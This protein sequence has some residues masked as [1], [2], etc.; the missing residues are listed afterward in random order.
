MNPMAV[1]PLLVVA[2]MAGPTPQYGP[3]PAQPSI[4]AWDSSS[5]SAPWSSPAPAAPA[6]SPAAPSWEAPASH[7][8]GASAEPDLSQLAEIQRQWERFLPYLPWLKG[9]DGAPG[10]FLLQFLF[11]KQVYQP[12]GLPNRCP[13]SSWSPRIGRRQC[14]W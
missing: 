2:A 11:C 3:L 6:W 13:W 8:S 12:S 9:Q 7:S 14:W 4:S 5:S 10:M 1:F